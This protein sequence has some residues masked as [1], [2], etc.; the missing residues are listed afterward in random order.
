MRGAYNWT[1]FLIIR[2]NMGPRRG[3]RTLV[4]ICLYG[5]KLHEKYIR[6]SI[7]GNNYMFNNL[8]VQID[9]NWH[10]A[11]GAWNSREHIYQ[12]TTILR[13]FINSSENPFSNPDQRLKGNAK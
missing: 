6:Q 13:D 12:A 3:D 7:F 11:R 9:K 1:I 10:T 2:G 8:L 5:L 4:F